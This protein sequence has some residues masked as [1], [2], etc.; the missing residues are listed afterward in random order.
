MPQA[1]MAANDAIAQA[2]MAANDAIAQADM[3]ANDAIT[4]HAN[5]TGSMKLC[6]TK[7]RV[8]RWSILLLHNTVGDV[9]WAGEMRAG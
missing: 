6:N 4:Q 9:L 5:I 1:D 2:D 3:A 7:L 8:V